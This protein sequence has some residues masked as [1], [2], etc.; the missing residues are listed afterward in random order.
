MCGSYNAALAFSWI[1]WLL[2]LGS[3]ILS[4][5]ELVMG[6]NNNAQPAKMMEVGNYGSSAPPQVVVSSTY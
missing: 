2:L 4:I 3:M 1:A 6:R 5:L